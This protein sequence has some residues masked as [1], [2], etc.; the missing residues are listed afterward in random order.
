MSLEGLM[1]VGSGHKLVFTLTVIVSA[2]AGREGPGSSGCRA[3][4]EV[5]GRGGPWVSW[6]D[7]EGGLLREGPA[8]DDQSGRYSSSR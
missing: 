7:D 2:G 4:L 5:G 8:P 1:L 3:R 6:R